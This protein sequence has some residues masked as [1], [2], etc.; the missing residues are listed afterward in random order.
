MR[1]RSSQ[2]ERA[3]DADPRTARRQAR[4]DD[5]EIAQALTRPGAPSPAVVA[6][7]GAVAG[8]R[9]VNTLLRATPDAGTAPAPAADAGTA[10][11]TDAGTAPTPAAD[12]GTAPA[13]KPAWATDEFKQHFVATVLAEA[14]TGQSQETDIGWVYF[15]LVNAAGGEGGLSKS[16]AFRDKK[17]LYKVWMQFQGDTT[18]A[19]DP[20]PQDKRSGFEGYTSVADY[21]T[22]NS[23]ARAQYDSRG[24]AVRDQYDR[25]FTQPDTNPIKGWTGQGNLNDIN[26]ISNK[27]IYWTKARA[28]LWLQHDDTTVPQLVKEI[29]KGSG[30][31]FVF[32]ADAIKAYY[33]QHPLP[34]EVKQWP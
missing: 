19:D 16:T 20:L 33:D 26:N 17:P 6:R 12:A 3:E 27:D 22:R 25:M 14:L 8:N 28:Y 24:K 23:W 34:A 1:R 15:N 30:R 18:Y 9:A 7:L 31:Q 21:C 13:E 32:N 2:P 5:R 4:V 10:P 11:A 29:G